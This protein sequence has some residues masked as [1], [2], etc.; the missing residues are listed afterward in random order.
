MPRS[1]PPNIHTDNGQKN[2]FSNELNI[3][4]KLALKNFGTILNATTDSYLLCDSKLQLLACNKSFIKLCRQITGRVPG[5]NF[6]LVKIISPCRLELVFSYLRDGMP[7]KEMEYEESYHEKS[8][9]HIHIYP[10]RLLS[11]KTPQV[12]ICIK[13]ISVKKAAEVECEKMKAHEKALVNSTAEALMLINHKDEI[14]A[15][16]HRAEVLM[17]K[18]VRK[19]IYNGLNLIQAV[20]VF[21]RADL[22]DKLVS[23]RQGNF[24]EYEVKYPDDCWLWI[25]LVPVKSTAGAINEICVCL[26]DITNR[27]L[28]E[29]QLIEKESQGR[30]LIAALAE[31]VIMQARGKLVLNMNKSVLGILET[32]EK[33]LKKHGFPLPGTIMVSRKNEPI[34]IDKIIHSEVCEGRSVKSMV[35]GITRKSSLKWLLIN[36]EPVI[37]NNQKPEACVISMTDI[38]QIIKDEEELKLLSNVVKETSNLIGITDAAGK[39]Q[40]VNEAFQ[41]ISGY[42]LDEVI[43]KKP[44]QLLAGPDKDKKESYRIKMALEKGIAV[45]GEILNYSKEGKKYWVHYN[46]HPVKDEQGNITRFFSI[47]SDITEKKQMQEE[48]Q[49]QEIRRQ[50]AIIRAS[51]KGQEKERNQ[52]GQELHDNINQ[53]L[54]ASKLSL[55]C[56]LNSKESRVYVESAFE[57]VKLAMSEIRNFSRHLVSPRFQHTSFETSLQDITINLGLET[58]TMVVVDPQIDQYLPDDIKLSLYRIAQEQLH[59]TAKYAKAT[60]ILVCLEQRDSNII[61]RI[62]DDGVGFDTTTH[63]KGIGI[64]NIM[65]RVEAYNGDVKLISSPGHGCQVKITIPIE[66]LTTIL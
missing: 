42:S 17:E 16:N 36:I 21:R 63:K 39:I 20:P 3:Q 31:G 59:N 51:I 5:T 25:S 53:I 9:F 7:G 38:T 60:S 15:F 44:G 52:L 26:R 48:M 1:S 65:N 34:D 13:D 58:I 32:N 12:C 62:E 46:I 27:K 50:K 24:M 29:E 6:N 47:Q 40:W 4:P 28:M 66:Q 14:I 64:C 61:L 57:N 8:W 43:N 30:S 33:E 11:G 10:V 55:D 35:V 22:K 45:E 18:F 41:K 49:R 19:G 56:A 54:A 37:R 23:V 2:F